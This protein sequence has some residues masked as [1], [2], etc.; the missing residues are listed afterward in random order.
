MEYHECDEHWNIVALFLSDQCFVCSLSV[1]IRVSHSCKSPILVLVGS[2][3]NLYNCILLCIYHRDLE[4][5]LSLEVDF[6]VVCIS[7]N[8][9]GVTYFLNV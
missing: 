4:L 6:I 3:A 9:I 7:F 5:L 8:L 2:S 1:F